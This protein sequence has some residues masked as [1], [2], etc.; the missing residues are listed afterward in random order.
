MPNSFFQ[1]KQ[2][3]IEQGKTAMKVCTDACLF[4]AYMEAENYRK[5]LDI[6][7]GTGLL[8][9][10][11]AQKTS[12]SIIGV[13]IEQ[14]AY[15]QALSNV[16]QSPFAHQIE[17]IHQSIQSYAEGFK[18]EKFDLIVSNPPFFKDNWKSEQKEKNLALH[19]ESLDFEDLLRAVSQILSPE[20]KFWVLLPPFEANVFAKKAASFHLRLV[21]KVNVY[22]NPESRIFRLMQAFV[23]EKEVFYNDLIINDLYIKD[24]KNE[25]TKEFKNLLKEY[26]LI[27]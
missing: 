3:K 5:I 25:Y 6:G 14:N 9:L 21:E 11:L 1:F 8:A 17:I 13:E 23:R 15:N 27:F 10:M 2:F 26:Y 7:T 20:G 24:S 16:Q 18:E 12:A 22:N 19:S 4:G